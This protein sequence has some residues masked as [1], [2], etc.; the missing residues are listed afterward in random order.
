MRCLDHTAAIALDRPDRITIDDI[1]ATISD[2][3][4]D[5]SRK[6]LIDACGVYLI[7]NSA[8]GWVYLGQSIRIWRRAGVHLSKLRCGNHESRAMQAAANEYGVDVFRFA[9]LTFTTPLCGELAEWGATQA[10][11]NAGRTKCYNVQGYD[12]VGRIGREFWKD[13]APH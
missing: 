1:D 6:S 11:R 3:M 13:A 4:A 10:M 7:V 9:V 8:N 5:G 2:A 12:C